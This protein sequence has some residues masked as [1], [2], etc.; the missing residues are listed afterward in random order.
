[1]GTRESLNGRKKKLP[2]RL[3]LAPRFPRMGFTRHVF[4]QLL[5]YAVRG[6]SNFHWRV[7]GRNPS[8]WPYKRNYKL[9][10]LQKF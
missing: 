6:G 10:K 5:I 2:F 1:M 8:A 3:S 4:L 9:Y 7:C